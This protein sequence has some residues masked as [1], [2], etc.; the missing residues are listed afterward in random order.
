MHYPM[1]V[2]KMLVCGGVLLVVLT[3]CD[4]NRPS[5]VQTPAIDWEPS[6]P[7]QEDRFETAVREYGIGYA[8]A[9][10]ARDFTVAQLTSTTTAP[11]IEASYESFRSQYISA[12]ADPR[13]YAGPLP[14]S[15]LEV[16]PDGDDAATVTVCYPISEWWIESGH[17]KPEIDLDADG[18]L[19][20]YT[21]GMDQGVLKVIDVMATV[22][23]CK[24]SKISV[25]SFDPVPEPPESISERDIRA[26]LDITQ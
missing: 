7:T 8:V 3:A 21:V 12:H 14:Y 15:V 25:G 26:P 18:Q 20:T 5:V 17:P 2:T 10:N 23:P 4:P 22:K 11:Q 24:I 19:A 9:F 1:T 6:A 16:A 13:V